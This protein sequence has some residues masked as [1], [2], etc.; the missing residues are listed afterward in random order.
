M[1]PSY[2]NCDFTDGGFIVLRNKD[3]TAIFR[4]PRSKFRPSHSDAL[5]LDLWTNGFN[6][7]NDAGSFSYNTTSNCSE[8][9]LVL[10]DIIQ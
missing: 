2:K 10:K 8:Y 9:F 4:Y 6:L 1:S 3:T 5:H 7:L